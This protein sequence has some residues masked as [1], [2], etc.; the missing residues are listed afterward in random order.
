MTKQVTDVGLEWFG[1]KSLDNV[2]GVIDQVKIGTGTD[3]PSPDDTSL[4]NPVYSATTADA[5]LTVEELSSDDGLVRATLTITGGSQV[6]AGTDISEF[7]VFVSNSGT[8]LFREVREAVTLNNGLEV[9]FRID[10]DIAR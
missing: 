9:E 4:Q 1:D 6:A 10:L 8:M 5:E 7:G 2:T 3:G